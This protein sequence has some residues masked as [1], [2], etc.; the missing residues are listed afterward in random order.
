[1]TVPRRIRFGMTLIELLVVIAI[2]AVLIGLLLPAV[3]RVR[4]SAMQTAC[5]NNLKQMGLALHGYYDVR[6][7]MPPAYLYDEKF[8]PPPAGGGFVADRPREF[9]NGQPMPLRRIFTFPG[10]GWASYLLPH[11]EQDA[12][13]RRI[14]FAQAI[15]AYVH[16]DVRTTILPIYVCPSDLNTG[17]FS[18]TNQKNDPIADAATN[19]YASCFGSGGSIGELPDK[20]TGIFYR[21]S[22]TTFA[23]IADG[24]STTLAIGERGAVLCQAPWAG[25]ISDGFVRTMPDA[26]IYL[27]A[28]EEPPTAVMARTGRHT[29]NQDY[30]EPYDFYSPHVGVGYFLFAD[31]SVRPLRPSVTPEVWAAIG[32]RAEGE[33]I[34]GPD[35]E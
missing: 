21:N 19:S 28:V 27:A 17:I 15:E 31:G 20:G 2:I 3:Q 8:V 24:L 11:V 18:V 26:P 6:K 22:R 35:L 34:N 10:W 23:E 16:R 1:M 33:P 5:R 29:L 13:Y 14:D 12:L 9:P 32:T 7:A 25:A 30:S 4:E